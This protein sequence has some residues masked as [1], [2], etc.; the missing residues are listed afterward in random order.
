[1]T[2][3]PLSARW[4]C[5]RQASRDGWL[6][7]RADLPDA[8][9]GLPSASSPITPPEGKDTRLSE[10]RPSTQNEGALKDRG[11][12]THRG[13]PEP[14][15]FPEETASSRL[16]SCLPQCPGAH[17]DQ[18]SQG[19][20]PLPR[21]QAILH[22]LSLLDGISP[23]RHDILVPAIGPEG[24]LPP[25]APTAHKP[26]PHFAGPNCSHST[27]SVP[28]P[29]WPVTT[30]LS[31]AWAPSWCLSNHMTWDGHT[32]MDSSHQGHLASLAGSLI[33]LRE[34]QPGLTEVQGSRC[35]GGSLYPCGHGF[36]AFSYV[37]SRNVYQP[38]PRREEQGRAVSIT[39]CHTCHQRG[40]PCDQA[41]LQGSCLT[42]AVDGDVHT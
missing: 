9:E 5:A 25:S 38:E 16:G 19:A 12:H 10:S 8:L 27:K 42:L 18:P 6:Y 20:S 33:V 36:Q 41:H 40:F 30:E 32:H 4:D 28:G 3:G 39:F 15:A 22:S 17:T 37:L 13:G 21:L 2:L 31:C 14:P 29:V 24:D 34:M 11:S 7:G 23:Y 26:A 35:T 1:M